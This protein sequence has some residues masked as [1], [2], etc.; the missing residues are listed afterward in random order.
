ME[1]KDKDEEMKE[2]N[3][4]QQVTMKKDKTKTTDTDKAIQRKYVRLYDLKVWVNLQW[5]GMWF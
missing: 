1:K 3:H 4:Q 2:T 5:K